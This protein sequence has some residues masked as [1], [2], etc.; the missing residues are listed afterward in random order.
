[1]YNPLVGAEADAFDGGETQNVSAR[2]PNSEVGV[3]SFA[4]EIKPYP[5]TWP[6][7]SILTVNLPSMPFI[8]EAFVEIEVVLPPTVVV[9]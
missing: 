3:P 6:A 1:M 7:V 9:S 8:E 2:T 4:V 5:E